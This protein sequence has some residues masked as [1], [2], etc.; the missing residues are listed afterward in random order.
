MTLHTQGLFFTITVAAPWVSVSLPCP[1]EK[2]I[3]RINAAAACVHMLK[4]VWPAE[5]CGAHLTHSSWGALSHIASHG[6]AASYERC[7]VH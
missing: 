5:A 2:Q 3:K 4:L 1:V 7:N 6:G